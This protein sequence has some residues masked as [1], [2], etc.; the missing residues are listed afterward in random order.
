MKELK[1][2][3]YY[4]EE[5]QPD[6]KLYLGDCA[7]IIPLLEKVDLIIT[8]PPYGINY[9]SQDRP[10]EINYEKIYGDDCEKELSWL[11]NRKEVM[12][13]FGANNFYQ[14][15]PHKGIWLC[16]DKRLS[17]K[18]DKMLGSAF[19]LAWCNR[20]T[21]YFKMYRVLHGGVVN[22]D[23]GSR[24]HPTQKPVMLFKMIIKDFFISGTILDPFMGSG[25]AALACKELKR[26]F[27]GIEINEKYCEI[28][29]KRLMNTQVP[30]L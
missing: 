8:D 18:A 15:L 1:D 30:M 4:H 9:Q 6:I 13:I 16:W 17:E 5:G 21:G 3:L 22:A 20:A 29:K 24:Y 26:N 25:T 19:E 14:Q 11:L 12:V 2:Y 28:A 7:E 23:G 10:N 27:I